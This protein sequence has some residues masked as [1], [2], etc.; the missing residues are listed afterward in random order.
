M[1]KGFLFFF[2]VFFIAFNAFCSSAA[3]NQV[4]LMLQDSTSGLSDQTVIYFQQ[5]TSVNYIFPE[6]DIKTFDTSQALPKIYSFSADNVPCYSNG[7]GDF[8]S[9][10]IIPLDIR[11]PGNGSYI[12]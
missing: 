9:S 4:T 6:D 8:T 10:T 12:F 3:K 7:Y 1:K 5:G 11:L 2:L